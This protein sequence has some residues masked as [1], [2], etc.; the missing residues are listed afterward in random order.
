MSELNNKLK[1]VPHRAGIYQMYNKSGQILYV[2]K[3]MDLNKRVRTYFNKSKKSYKI[4][5]M[6]GLVTDFSFTMTDTHLEARL[7]ECEMIKSLKPHFNTQMK[8]DSRYTY[9]KITDNPRQQP[10]TIMDEYS[11]NTYGPFRS[12][13]QVNNF[14]TNFSHLFPIIYKSGQFELDYQILPKGLNVS[15]FFENRDNLISIFSSSFEMNQLISIIKE[16]MMLTAEKHQFEQAAV[17]R[18]IFKRLETISRI[19]FKIPKLLA[20]EF[21]LCIPVNGGSKLFFIRDGIIIS[22][23]KLLVKSKQDVCEFFEQNTSKEFTNQWSDKANLDFLEI[24]LSEIQ[25]YPEEWIY[26]RS[27]LFS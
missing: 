27:K 4:E 17:Y 2:G 5:Q 6:M 8:N 15:E 1:T 9:L 13:N 22:K 19:L 18:D 21:I 16:K 26:S 12:R 24:L 11:E 14:I 25:T 23:S 10:L 20:E 3:S 7:L